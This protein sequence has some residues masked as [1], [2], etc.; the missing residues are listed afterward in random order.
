MIGARLAG[1]VA[2]AAG[3]VLNPLMLARLAGPAGAV[4]VLW[5]ELLL[6]TCSGVLLAFGLW[7]LLSR[8]AAAWLTSQW[9]PITVIAIAAVFALVAVELALTLYGRLTR[10][11]QMKVVNREFAYDI[12]L[13]SDR[14]RDAEFQR[15]KP[16]D[17][18]RVLLIG[19][20]MIYG[21]AVPQ[22]KT[23]PHLL[24]T[25]LRQST[26]RPYRV[27]NLGIAGATPADYVDIAARFADYDPDIVLVSVYPDNDVIVRESAI[28]WL[29]RREV[30][31]VL[32]LTL[33]RLL[34]GCPYPW[35]RRY[36]VDPVYTEAACRSQMNPFLLARAAV[37]DNEAYYR[38]LAEA[39]D[40][41]P[42]VKENLL[43]VRQIFSGAR[44]AVAVLPSKL[45][46]DAAYFPELRKIGFTLPDHVIDD[47]VQQ[48]MRAWAP[49]A[50][51]ELLDLL[52]AL[53]AADA[54]PGVAVY[55]LVDDHFNVTGNEVIAA[56]LHGW[57][58]RG[59]NTAP[60][61]GDVTR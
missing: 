6:W 54:R 18:I 53:R 5:I 58:V 45:Q 40:A 46:T 42:F 21:T 24:Q 23:I 35:V 16:Q 20:S 11:R 7:L 48:R 32:D 14:F 8:R 31:R 29:K 41:D 59:R 61:G 47:G 56:F 2:I 26:G 1:L 28:A 36:H 57:I 39:F 22:D 37:P 27:F 13:N 51:V 34:E 52:P 38:E 33:N 25:R 3:A 10:P 17:E 19:D 50:G 12:S 30:Y 9:I 44:F 43:R 60:A 49:T 55:H 15:E 4:H